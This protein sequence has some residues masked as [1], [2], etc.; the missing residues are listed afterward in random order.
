MAVEIRKRETEMM[1]NTMTDM[2]AAEARIST[3]KRKRRKIKNID[4]VQ[5]KEKE[6]SVGLCLVFVK[7]KVLYS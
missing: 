6:I 4:L 5:M 2:H 7:T 3:K 1:T